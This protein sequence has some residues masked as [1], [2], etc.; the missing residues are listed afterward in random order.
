M[1]IISIYASKGGKQVYYV[2]RESDRKKRPMPIKFWQREQT[3]NK[4]RKNLGS[5]DEFSGDI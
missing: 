3:F 2:N 4:L 5:R 1:L